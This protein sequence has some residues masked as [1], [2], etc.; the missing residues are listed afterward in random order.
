MPFSIFLKNISC[1]FSG[2]L[3]FEEFSTHLSQ[4]TRVAL[5][6]RNGSGKSTLLKVLA[7]HLPPLTGSIEAPDAMVLY[8]AKQYVHHDADSSLTLSGGE[9]AYAELARAF[10]LQPDLLLLDEPTTHLDKSH[11]RLLLRLIQ[12]FSGVLIVATH[13]VELLDH[14]DCLWSIEQKQVVCFQ[15]MYQDY[16]TQCNQRLAQL[17]EEL[18][19]LTLKHKQ[20]HES[21]MREQE[22][23]KKSRLKG[24]KSIEHKKWP[25]VRSATKVDRAVSTSHDKT[26]ELRQQ[27]SKILDQKE[28][29]KNIPHVL[30]PTFSLKVTDLER[31]TV[32]SI[33]E[34]IIGYQEPV[35][36][37]ICFS[38]AIGERLALVGDNGSGK[39]TLFKALLHDAA[40]K[41]LGEWQVPALQNIVYIDQHQSHLNPNETVY[42]AIKKSMPNSSQEVIRTHLSHFLFRSS[43][44][45]SKQVRHLSGGQRMR[46]CLAE[47]A[48]DTPHLLLLDEITNALDLET[49]Q[50]VID[51]LKVYPG[52][53][54]VISHDEPFLHAIGCTHQLIC[55]QGLL[56]QKS[57]P[58]NGTQIC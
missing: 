27:Q 35:L 9:R 26:A 39:S 56:K 19:H 32:V 53:F 6:G 7:G 22:R 24:Q 57:F 25:T 3:C 45:V 31:G 17:E 34:G 54:I 52:A 23:A 47:L 51:V 36:K 13:D 12:R 40:I 1:G 5:I 44:E 14:F 46:L 42:E 8:F 55:E 49:R 10:Q 16:I 50:H 29:L 28:Q 15:G 58:L 2:T 38:L 37:Q 11:R 21:L 4:G 41:R 20:N 48:A 33:S 30:K 43:S 18:H